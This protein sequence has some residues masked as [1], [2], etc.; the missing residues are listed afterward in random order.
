MWNYE[1][2]LRSDWLEG[3]VT[4]QLTAFL[5]KRQNTQLRDSSGT[6]G[7]FKYFTSNE[8][9]AQ[10]YGL[11]AS[12]TWWINS[13]WKLNANLGLTE[14]QA[15]NTMRNLSNAPLYTYHVRLDYAANNGFFAK[16]EVAGSDAY[17][18]AD[19]HNEKRSDFTIVNTTLGYQFDNWTL[20]LWAKNLL[21]QGYQKRVSFFGNEDPNYAK[22]RY[23][24]PAD[25]QHFGV[26][27]NYSW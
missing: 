14:A 24:N 15:D 7:L 5:L 6:G 22:K 21:N 17:Y 8:G 3:Q 20:T 27:L 11:E 9:D 2:G 16:L 12:S 13:N 10:H 26:T 18:Q 4:S 23:E 1:I 19:F 25:P